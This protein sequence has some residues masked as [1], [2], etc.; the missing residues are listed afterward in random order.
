M[1]VRSFAISKSPTRYCCVQTHEP[2]EE[3]EMS[4]LLDRQCGHLREAPGPSAEWLDRLHA[5]HTSPVKST[6][7]EK[8]KQNANNSHWDRY[9]EPSSQHSDQHAII[10]PSSQH[11]DQHAI[12]RSPNAIAFRSAAK[13]Q[14]QSACRW[15]IP[16]HQLLRLN[17]TSTVL[18]RPPPQNPKKNDNSTSTQIPPQQA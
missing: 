18:P 12:A 6:S 9:Q 5:R 15:H 7:E 10:E 16:N 11:S 14:L 17:I 1:V 3:L 13:L 4:D 8:Q 2:K